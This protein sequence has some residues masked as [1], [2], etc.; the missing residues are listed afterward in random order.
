MATGTFQVD[1]S[2][3]GGRGYGTKQLSFT[4]STTD[5]EDKTLVVF[6]M[7]YLVKGN[8]ETLIGQH[9]EI[10][11]EKQTTHIPKMR[12]YAY[13]METG[14]QTAGADNSVILVYKEMC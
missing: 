11:D 9:T 14:E 13:D 8:K 6:E 2:T 7:L 4:F 12:T 10:M 1:S 5:L 3:D